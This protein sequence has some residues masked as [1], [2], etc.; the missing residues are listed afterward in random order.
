MAVCVIQVNGRRR[1]IAAGATVSVLLAELRLG[2]RKIAV[3]KNGAIVPKS[4]RD[5]ETLAAG[6]A[7][8][9]VGAVGGG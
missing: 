6:D 2:G 3:E 9:I 5:S 8:E 1:E 4:R 7:V